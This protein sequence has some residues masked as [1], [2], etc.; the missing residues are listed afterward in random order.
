MSPENSSK[1][2]V[3]NIPGTMWCIVEQIAWFLFP[4]FKYPLS[5]NTPVNP[6]VTFLGSWISPILFSFF[7]I[8]FSQVL[9]NPEKTPL[10][11]FFCNYDLS[12]MPSGTKVSWNDYW[13]V[14]YALFV[15]QIGVLTFFLRCWNYLHLAFT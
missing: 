2:S 4:W 15:R 14:F 13:I 1:E 6:G 5:F 7:I 8:I 9:S 3:D 12:D 11:S 10:H